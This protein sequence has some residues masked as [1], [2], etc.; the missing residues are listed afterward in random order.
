MLNGPL[1]RDSLVVDKTRFKF[2]EVSDQFLILQPFTDLGSGERLVVRVTFKDRAVPAQATFA[3]ITHPTEVDGTVEVD[4]RANTPEALIAALAERDAQVETLKAKCE[5]SGPIGVVRSG[6]IDDQGMKPSIQFRSDMTAANRG[7]LEVKSSAGNAGN[8]WAVS[9]FQLRNP[10]GQKAWTLGSPV[11]LGADGKP[12][13]VRSVWMEKPQLGPGEE[14]L[15][16]VETL[17]PP[18]DAGGAFRLELPDRES[19]RRLSVRVARE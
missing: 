16:M 11:L 7:S 12:V 18:W 6:L 17:V 8:T 3:V 13:K 1:D 14:G 9:T 2:A 19:T 4:R 5:V 15:L 10:Q